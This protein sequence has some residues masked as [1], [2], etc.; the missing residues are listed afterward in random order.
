MKTVIFT[1]EGKRFEIELEEGLADYIEQNLK[2]NDIAFDRNNTVSKLL[3]AYLKGMQ[4]NFNTEKHIKI[5]IN[6][7]EL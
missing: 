3:K 2:D 5:L 1:I 6:K 7:T 4:S